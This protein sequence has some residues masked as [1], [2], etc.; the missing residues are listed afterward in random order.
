[1]KTK[2]VLASMAVLG[3]TLTT[4]SAQL[5]YDFDTDTTANWNVNVLGTGSDANFFFDYGTVGIP[6]APNS[7]GGTTTGLRLRANQFGSTAGFPS[8][9]SVSPST[10]LNLTGEYILSFDMWLNFNGPAPGG[11]SGSTQV[12]GA[13][14]GTAGA[15]AQIAGGAFDSISFGATGEG[16][17]GVD[18]RVYVPAAQTGLA[19]VSG[20]FAAGTQSTARNNTDPYY[21]GFG[22]VTA[23]AGQ[24]GSY[25]QQTGTTAAGTLGWAWHEVQIISE[26][27]TVSWLV[28]GLLIAS[29]DA[30]TAG[31][32]GGGNILFS[33]YD[34]NSSVSTEATS[35]DLLFGLFDNVR[36]SPIP[37]PSTM[38]LALLGVL[39]LLAARRNR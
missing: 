3:L 7:V 14:V 31:T 23:P 32:L 34:I 36:L 8:G 2:L 37:E 10:S 26:G 17:S 21:A 1:M 11:G 24:V 28:D 19:E 13:G 20:V 38:A 5:L 22:G 18:Y 30:T 12:T 39:G 6:S 27:N 16:G 9:V 29:V 15:S 25:P 4:A 35:A 33:Q